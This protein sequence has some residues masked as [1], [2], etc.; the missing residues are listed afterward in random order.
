MSFF[1]AKEGMGESV[2]NG[3]ERSY[4]EQKKKKRYKTPVWVTIAY[5]V[6][7]AIC[8][9]SYVFTSATGF[10]IPGLSPLSLAAVVGVYTY[11]HYRTNKED[12]D[13]MLRSQLVI[14]GI[15]IGANVISALMQI[16]AALVS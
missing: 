8:V 6:G 7:I 3:K 16:Y 10:L 13:G 4:M 11:E 2:L 15:I 12:K 14:L 5:V 9:G 1:H